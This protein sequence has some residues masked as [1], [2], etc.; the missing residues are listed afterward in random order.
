MRKAGKRIINA[1]R[2][3]CVRED[4]ERK[5][6]PLPERSLRTSA[7]R[8]C[9]QLAGLIFELEPMLDEYYT[10]RKWG[11]ETG[12]A[13]SGAPRQAGPGHVKTFSLGKPRDGT[14]LCRIAQGNLREHGQTL[15]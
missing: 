9:D 15:A 10:D 11:P 4:I 12:L 3:I 2:S 8:E 7:G 13:H 5:D 6:D 1:E 14:G